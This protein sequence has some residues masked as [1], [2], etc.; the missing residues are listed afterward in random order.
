[1]QNSIYKMF[2]LNNKHKMNEIKGQISGE[3]VDGEVW[4]ML[5]K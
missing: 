2:D 1:M 4:T 5:Q 3:I